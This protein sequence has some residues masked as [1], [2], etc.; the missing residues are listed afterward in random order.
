M[1]RTMGERTFYSLSV[2]STGRRARDDHVD[3][4]LRTRK[5]SSETFSGFRVSDEIVEGVRQG[6][7]IV[8]LE[9]AIITHGMPHPHNIET[10]FRLE[11]II[12]EQVG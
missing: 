10:A 8:A 9:S 3:R 11:E 6:L 4:L 5:N 7:P 2:Q 12:R 1:S